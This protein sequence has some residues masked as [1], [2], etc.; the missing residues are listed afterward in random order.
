M[1][2]RASIVE[3]LLTTTIVMLFY[4]VTS[5]VGNVIVLNILIKLIVKLIPEI[6]F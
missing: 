5:F 3:T 6:V 1:A 4:L 2:Y